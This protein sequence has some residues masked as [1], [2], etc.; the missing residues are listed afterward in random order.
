[1]AA[2][3]RERRRIIADHAFRDRDAAGHLEALKQ[4]SEAIFAEQ[5]RLRPVTPPRLRHYLTQCSYDK[6]LV[7]LEG[8]TPEG[9]H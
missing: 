5:E 4:V 7:W 6:A 8:G 1:M 2:L 9:A 3:L